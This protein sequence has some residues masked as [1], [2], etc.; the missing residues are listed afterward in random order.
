MGRSTPDLAPFLALAQS[1]GII[2]RMLPVKFPGAGSE[3]GCVTDAERGAF[4]VERKAPRR[5]L[6]AQAIPVA[7]PLRTIGAGDAHVAGFLVTYLEAPEPI[8]LERGLTVGR[9]AG[10]MHVSCL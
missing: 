5:V 6:H 10:A 8:R 9:L 1:E 2:S 3:A 7:E 4:G